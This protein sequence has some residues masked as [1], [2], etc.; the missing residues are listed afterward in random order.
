MPKEVNFTKRALEAL[1]AA[2]QRLTYHD[3][4]T[5]GLSL[6]L[7]PTG[8]RSFFWFRRVNGSPLWLTIGE[9]PALS[10]E[11]ARVPRCAGAICR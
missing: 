9:F 1:K 8:H 6:L 4:E 10:V 5:P 11:N 2:E 7:Q 3:K